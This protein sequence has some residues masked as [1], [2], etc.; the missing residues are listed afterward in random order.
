MIQIQLRRRAIAACA[1]LLCL[2]GTALAGLPMTCHPLY[3]G[4]APLLPWGKGDWRSTDPGYDTK[5]L[6]RDMQRLLGGD[7]PLLPR[8]EN[9]RRAAIYGLSQPAIA[10]ELLQATIAR[11]AKAGPVH[12]LAWF[13]AAYMIETFRQAGLDAG[14]E[15]R[16][17]VARPSTAWPELNARDGYRMLGVLLEREGE[18][19]ELEFAR[20][21]MMRQGMPQHFQR[22]AA[23]APKDALL[24]RNLANFGY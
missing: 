1:A 10:R 12:R 3:A 21:L 14:P 16:G 20:A 17:F 8:M 4:D 23:L 18:S 9:I 13:D 5:N 19:A 2:S 7:A 6:T 11:A 24:V 15:S 22:A